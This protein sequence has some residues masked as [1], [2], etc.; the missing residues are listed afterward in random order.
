MYTQQQEL[1]IYKRI[2]V[3]REVYDTLRDQKRQTKQSMAKIICNL[4]LEKYGSTLNSIKE[5]N[6]RKR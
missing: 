2:G 5:K 6:I 4:V 1:E 3:T